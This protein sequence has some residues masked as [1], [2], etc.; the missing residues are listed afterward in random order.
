MAIRADKLTL[1]NLLEHPRTAAPSGEHRDIGELLG[2][3]QVIPLHCSWME[4]LAAIRAGATRLEAR[5][6]GHE[7]GLAVFV[8]LLP[9]S[10]VRLI[11]SR[12][13]FAAAGFAPRLESIPPPMELLERL[14]RVAT[15]TVLAQRLAFQGRSHKNICS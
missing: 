11:V 8:L 14:V 5:V 9:S 10:P 3:R 2:P 6:P 7:L 13:V 15:A 1:R 4:F 12:G